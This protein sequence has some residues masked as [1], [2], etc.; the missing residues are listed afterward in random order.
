M[1]VYRAL[2]EDLTHPTAES[3]YRR[4]KHAQRGMSQ[5]TV[6]R[7][8]EFLEREGLIRRV[9]GPEAVA[10]FDAN[11]E[12]HQ[13]LFCRV[14]GSLID[15]VVPGLSEPR[16]PR[17]R[18]FKVEELDIR[19]VGRCRRCSASAL[20]RRGRRPAAARRLKTKSYTTSRKGKLK[21]LNLK[22]PKH[23]RT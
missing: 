2:A 11:I 23:T 5:A 20:K 4:L 8:L 6:Y 16:L 17:V 18:G 22:E 19:L 9:S 15:V 7:T 10:R 12:F 3:V 13:H 14:C 21:W 1:A